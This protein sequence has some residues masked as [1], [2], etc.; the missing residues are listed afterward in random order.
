MAS[1]AG[2][3]LQVPTITFNPAS[4]HPRTLT[5][6]GISRVDLRRFVVSYQVQGE[7]LTTA[8]GV[9]GT[10]SGNYGVAY[11]LPAQPGLGS[12]GLHGLEAI[13]WGLNDIR[14]SVTG[15]GRTG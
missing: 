2:A 5:K 1:L 6:Y 13:E 14:T 8:G 11:A 15:G 7:A 12:V 4:L 10:P 9:T 3:M